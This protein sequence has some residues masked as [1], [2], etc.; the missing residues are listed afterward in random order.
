MPTAPEN[1]PQVGLVVVTHGSSGECL[2]AAAAGLVGPLA[3]ATS[4]SVSLSD[5]FDD[6][7]RHVERACDQVD[8]GV[9]LLILADIH[10]SSPFRACLAM[11]DGTR[12]VEIVCGVNLPMLIKL[13]TVDRRGMR[14]GE[15]AELIKEVGKRSIRLGSELTGKLAFP[16]EEHH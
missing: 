12:S 1:G 15:M 2:L 11:F 7:V 8:A 9:G 3:S 6:I 5:R 10:G 4:V 16:R 13:A 14:P